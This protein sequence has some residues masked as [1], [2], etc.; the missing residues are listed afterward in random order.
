MDCFE[1]HSGRTFLFCSQPP[2]SSLISYL[3]ELYPAQHIQ[4]VLAIAHSQVEVV[5][6]SSVLI[7]LKFRLE[8]QGR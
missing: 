5:Q 8:A 2:S 4:P 3:I 7:T 6:P 1:E